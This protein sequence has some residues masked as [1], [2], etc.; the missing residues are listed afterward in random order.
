[1][2]ASVHDRKDATRYLARMRRDADE[3]WFA[4][5]NDAQSGAIYREDE[6]AP[7]A[8]LR[9]HVKKV[10]ALLERPKAA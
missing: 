4:L 5:R 7:V 6:I 3:L 10:Q 1:V 9:A 8:E 2:S